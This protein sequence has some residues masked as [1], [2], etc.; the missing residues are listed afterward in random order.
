ME[1]NLGKT[2]ADWQKYGF[3]FVEVID[4]KRQ[5]VNI[6]GV[7]PSSVK[8]DGDTVAS[9]AGSATDF[10]GTGWADTK[11]FMRMSQDTFA[12]L[13]AD[14]RMVKRD[15]GNWFKAVQRTPLTVW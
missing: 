15:I 11:E 10:T 4:F 7:Y 6:A 12:G 14:N 13:Q 5:A 8:T 2:F 3:P 1:N 9:P